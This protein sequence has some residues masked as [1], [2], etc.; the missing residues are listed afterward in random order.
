MN[1]I[2][3]WWKNILIGALGLA[4]IA[5]L[6]VGLM[7]P[8]AGALPDCA[9]PSVFCVALVTDNNG[10]QEPDDN[11][12][13]W[14][15]LQRA[16]SELGAQVYVIETQNGLDYDKNI[17]FFTNAN[18][19]VI[20]T[21]GGTM[22]DA[23]ASAAGKY[24]D[25]T[26]IGVDQTQPPSESP[27]PNFIGLT[28]PDDQIGFLAGTLAALT[29]TSGKV[30]AV[31]PTDFI[32][33]YAARGQGFT[34]GAININPDIVATVSY[35]NDVLADRAFSDPKWGTDTANQ[36]IESDI[37]V[38]YAD[39]GETGDATLDAAI[40]KG[41]PA[42]STN[43]NKD[44]EPLLMARI[45]GDVEASLFDLIQ[46]IYSG[47]FTGE[48]VVSGGV[49]ILFQQSS[50]PQSVLARLAEIR[51][52]LANGSLQTGVSQPAPI[53]TE[54]TI[55][56]GIPLFSPTATPTNDLVG[57]GP[58]GPVVTPTLEPTP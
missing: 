31:L 37:D 10:L 30:A 51:Q 8:L 15:A 20:V 40:A 44:T 54:T 38:V 57:P 56:P 11:A 1:N 36:L 7:R 53:A 12:A 23:T 16:K 5:L 35:H 24:P 17:A 22:T 55:T 43:T 52:E 46:K 33:I 34:N 27:L 6:L 32:S 29:T 21:V 48:L 49:K 14:T 25:V 47:S 58:F 26:F 42:I 28:F 13:A 2:R 50:V 19:D 4:V 41:I 9:A 39:G 3:F 18:F 45:T